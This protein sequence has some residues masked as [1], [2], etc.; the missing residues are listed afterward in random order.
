MEQDRTQIRAKAFLE[1]FTQTCNLTQAARVAGIGVRQHYR[2]LEN[3]AYRAKFEQA[4]VLASQCL[5]DR[6][7]EGALDGWDEPVYYK[8]QL[9]GTVRRFDLARREIL[10]R[11]HNPAKYGAK[12]EHDVHGAIEII[13]RLQAGRNRLA[14][15][16]LAHES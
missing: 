8:G 9:C 4:K 1:A 5:E 3:E 6:I 2:W 16:T 15:A 11:A 13:E 14:K 7:I 10:L 12:V